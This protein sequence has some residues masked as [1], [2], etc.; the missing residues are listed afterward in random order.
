MTKELYLEKN[1]DDKD[2]CNII[3]P[4]EKVI[5]GDNNVDEDEEIDTILLTRRKCLLDQIKNDIDKSSEDYYIPRPTNL[6]DWINRIKY[7]LIKFI[8]RSVVPAQCISATIHAITHGEIQ[9]LAQL[10]HMENQ[11]KY[12]EYYGEC[13]ICLDSMWSKDATITNCHHVFHQQCLV[14]LTRQVCPL[15][16]QTIDLPHRNN[17]LL[18]KTNFLNN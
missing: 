2:M 5:F 4:V 16:N 8:Q 10:T 13:T 11:V 3:N 9:S 1:K 7:I 15:C 17:K 14:Q 18:E 12:Q 6:I